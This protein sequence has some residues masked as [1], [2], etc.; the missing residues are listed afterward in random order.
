MNTS[1]LLGSAMAIQYGIAIADL[2]YEPGYGKSKVMLLC[3]VKRCLAM[4]E[5][6]YTQGT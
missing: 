5:S 1:L 6:A 3:Q 4:R 2:K